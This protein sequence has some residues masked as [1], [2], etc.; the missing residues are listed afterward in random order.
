MIKGA[1]LLLVDCYLG[2]ESAE[3][4]DGP[5][6]G[7]ESPPCESVF[8]NDQNKQKTKLM[9]SKT[10]K[11]IRHQ[12]KQIYEIPPEGSCQGG[13]VEEEEDEGA[14]WRWHNPLTYLKKWD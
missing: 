2:L 10:A 14:S 13:E 5:G 4:H 11:Q 9:N 6:G 7:R 1:R 12:N 8:E 3:D